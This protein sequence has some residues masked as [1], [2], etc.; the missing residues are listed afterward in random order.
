[1]DEFEKQTQSVLHSSFVLGNESQ[2]LALAFGA[3]EQEPSCHD[4]LLLDVPCSLHKAL[5]RVGSLQP[6]GLSRLSIALF[7][8]S[9]CDRFRGPFASV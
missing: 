3:W 7:R 5:L 8:D 9:P 1:M 4:V 6:H 2:I